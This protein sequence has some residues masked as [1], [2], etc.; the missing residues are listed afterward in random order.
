MGSMSRINA[1]PG[2]RTASCS[3]SSPVTVR[4]TKYRGPGSVNFEKPRP[5]LEKTTGPAPFNGKATTTATFSE[6]GDYVLHLT[7]NDYSGDG[8]G[9]FGCCWTTSLVKVSVKP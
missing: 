2:S 9:R 4:W 7:G 3:T 5:E 6:P 1:W 8:G